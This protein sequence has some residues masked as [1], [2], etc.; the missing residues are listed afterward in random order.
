VSI[1]YFLLL[2][3]GLL[4]FLGDAFGRPAPSPRRVASL[5]ALGLAFWI[6]VYLIQAAQG[7]G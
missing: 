1:V 5:T 7:L 3:V 6:T 4:C 2:L